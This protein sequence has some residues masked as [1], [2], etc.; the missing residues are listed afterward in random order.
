LRKS[1]EYPDSYTDVSFEIQI[2]TVL[3]HAWAEIEHDLGYKTV[4]AVPRDIR[5]EF[6]RVAGLLE[7]ADESFSRI[8]EATAEYELEVRKNIE[9]DKAD[10]MTID[11]VTLWA[12]MKRSNFMQNFLYE[13][14]SISG[15]RILDVN[16]ESY[17]KRFDALGINTLGELKAFIEEQRPHALRMARDLLTDSEIDELISTVGFYYVC[18]SKF[19]FNPDGID[20]VELR[21]Y[22]TSYLDTAKQIK[23]EEDR[24]K[25]QWKKYRTSQSMIK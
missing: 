15:A 2:R 9:E 14:A 6:S 5:R 16:P 4:F 25:A 12:F 11:R 7:I 1:D 3:Q 19:I 22:V 13:I 8:R 20:E 17:L 24:I 18:R 10:D 21:R 23:D